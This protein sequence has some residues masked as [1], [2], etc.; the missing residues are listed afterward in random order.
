MVSGDDA[1]V[2]YRI[3][4]VGGQGSVDLVKSGGSYTATAEMGTA[5]PGSGFDFSSL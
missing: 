2:Q 5:L 4:T 3:D 1:A